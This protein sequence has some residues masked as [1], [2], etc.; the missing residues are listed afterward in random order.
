MFG[1]K[2]ALIE[3]RAI[4]CPIACFFLLEDVGPGSNE[5]TNFLPPLLVEMLVLELD[6]FFI[7]FCDEDLLSLKV[8]DSFCS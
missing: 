6:C 2:V 4:R 8:L 7:C 3:K 1:D 5:I